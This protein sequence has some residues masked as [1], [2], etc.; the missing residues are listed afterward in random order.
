MAAL[1][2]SPRLAH[3][4]VGRSTSGSHEDGPKAAVSTLGL[5]LT[6]SQPTRVG[7]SDGFK[8]PLAC[9][10]CLLKREV[11][12]VPERIIPERG[13]ARPTCLSYCAFSPSSF[14]IAAQVL[15]TRFVLSSGTPDCAASFT[16]PLILPFLRGH[17][18]LLDVTFPRALYF[19]LRPCADSPPSLKHT[20]ERTI[21]IYLYIIHE[22][23][24]LQQETKRRSE[25]HP[26]A[27]L[28]EA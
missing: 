5:C 11:E 15:S 28:I 26:T 17:L 3:V 16:V 14:I 19:P 23:W 22:D 2:D 18:R 27:L 12:R 13:S 24:T 10:S 20:Q 4:P 6:P 25:Q 7:E 1:A 8:N 21:H 9:H